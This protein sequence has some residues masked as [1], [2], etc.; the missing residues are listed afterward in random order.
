MPTTWN[1]CSAALPYSHRLRVWSACITS[2]RMPLAITAASPGETSR[3]RPGSLRAADVFHALVE[4]RP[5]RGAF[6]PHVAA[7]FVRA[8]A[9]VGRLDGDAVNAVVDA[10]HG[11]DVARRRRAWPAG[12]TDRQ[13]D[14]LRLVAQ[15]L[16]NKEIARR[17]VVS[18]RTA[19]T[20]FRMST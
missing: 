14:V 19:E 9:R 6:H 16:S 4:R 13:V 7:E 10:A 15:G 17:L 18:P 12:L 2:V 8:E 20:T 3:P 11:D 5:Y 1:A